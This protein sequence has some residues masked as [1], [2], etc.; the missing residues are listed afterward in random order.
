MTLVLH[1]TS[2]NGNLRPSENP[3][4]STRGRICIYYKSALP[5]NV[6]NIHYLQESI[7]FEL[8]IGDKLCNFV[9]WYR[10]PSQKQD[11][12]ERFS[13]YLERNLDRLFQSNPFLVIGDFN[14]KSSN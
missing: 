10:P 4:N 2:D 13:G 6:P 12:F 7:N 1:L 14:V 8:K 11:E 9:S 5:L 3:S